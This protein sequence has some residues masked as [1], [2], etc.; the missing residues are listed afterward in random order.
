MSERKV[1]EQKVKELVRTWTASWLNLKPEHQ[2]QLCS[3]CKSTYEPHYMKLVNGKQVCK[4]CVEA[5]LT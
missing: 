3:D 4:G 5:P 2:P 1:D